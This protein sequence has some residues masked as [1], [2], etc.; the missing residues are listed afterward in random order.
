MIKY[1]VE[2]E[3]YDRPPI[4][5][6]DRMSRYGTRHCGCLEVTQMIM[7]G[8]FDRFPTLKIY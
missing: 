3:G 2:P 5:I 6:V 4:D 1:P 8:L 7:T